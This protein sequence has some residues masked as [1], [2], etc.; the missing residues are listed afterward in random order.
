[1]VLI[2]AEL[3]LLLF[4]LCRFWFLLIFVDLWRFW[5]LLVHTGVTVLVEELL[6]CED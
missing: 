1:M 2:G 5:F 3:L 4:D 6:V